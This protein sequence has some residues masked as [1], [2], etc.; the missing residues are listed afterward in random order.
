[1]NNSQ[2]LLTWY[3]SQIN[4]KLEEANEAYNNEDYV[5]GNYLTQEASNF[6]KLLNEIKGEK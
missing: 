4:T 1:M 3:K 2:E 6:Q 5:E